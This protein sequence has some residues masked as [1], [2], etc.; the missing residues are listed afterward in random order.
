MI[1]SVYQEGWC[2]IE[3]VGHKK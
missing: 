2:S 1:Y 3:F